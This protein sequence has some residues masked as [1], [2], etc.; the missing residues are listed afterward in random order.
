M[1]AEISQEL[2]DVDPRL[3]TVAASVFAVGGVLSSS[4]LISV[5]LLTA[6]LGSSFVAWLNASRP[7]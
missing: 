5:L 4:V 1:T 7:E 2:D 6:A 3:L